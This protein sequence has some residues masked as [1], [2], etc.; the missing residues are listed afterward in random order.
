VVQQGT[1]TV[2]SIPKPVGVFLGSAQNAL[3]STQGGTFGSGFVSLSAVPQVPTTISITNTNPA[4]STPTTI[5]V[6][7]G[8]YFGNFIY[9]TFPVPTATSGTLTASANGASTSSTITVT[10]SPSPS[11]QSLFIPLPSTQT[12]SSGQ[13]LT[14][15]VTLTGPAYL[16]GMVVALSTDTPSAVTLPGSVTVPAGRTTANF[17]VTAAQVSAP[18]TVTISATLP[19]FAPVPVTL[20]IIPGPALAITSYTLSPYTMIGPGVVTN[21]TITLNQPAPAGGV[22]ITLSA[23]PGAAK[24]ASSVTVPQGQNSASFTVQGSSVSGSTVVS[25]AASYKGVLAPLGTMATTSLTVAPTDTLKIPKAPTWSTSTHVLTVTATSTN[26]QAIIT[27]L[28]ANGNV[29][30]GTMTG[31]GAGNY[32]FQTTIAS[33]ASVNI[34]SNLGGS[35]GQGVTVVP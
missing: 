24:V 30:I 1:V 35:T 16:G 32:T 15:T 21:G 18:T 23:A 26:P 3:L 33:I 31:D 4:L 6:P 12:W 17:F 2:A 13:T 22:T 34:K 5:Q 7:A 25:L 20:T 14:A 8:Q 28:N 10:A 19:G 11:I 27:V 29:P 9:T